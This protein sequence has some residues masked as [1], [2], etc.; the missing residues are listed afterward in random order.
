[1]DDARHPHPPVGA[2]PGL[3]DAYSPEQVAHR[4]RDVGVAKARRGVLD[5][6]V[7]AVLAGAFIA[8]GSALS[9]AVLAGTSPG[10]GPARILSGVAFS[11]GLVLVVVA[12]AELFTGNNLLAMAWASRLVTTRD[13]ARN[14][15]LVYAGNLVGAVAT[16]LLVAGSGIWR[17]HGGALGL[18]TV[19][20]AIDKCE[21]EFGEVLLRGV[22]ANALVCLALWLCQAG[23]SVTDRILALLLPTIALVALGLEHCVANMY[24]LAIGALLAGRVAMP[25]ELAARADALDAA[26]MA[27]NLVPVTLGN[28]VGG[29]LLVAAVYW[30]VYLRHGPSGRPPS[31]R[32]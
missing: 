10:F 14:W 7:L 25:H 31:G 12:G 6:L 16:A 28:M 2:P 17:L 22:L 23:R 13:V 18:E 4:V 26:G 32:P 15:V 5:T 11:L 29:T 3:P 9:T 8:L 20:A 27:G 19:R 21:L 1:M 24:V 30:L